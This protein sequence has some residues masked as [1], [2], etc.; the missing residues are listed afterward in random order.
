MPNLRNESEKVSLGCH[1]HSGQEEVLSLS[2][3][4]CENLWAKLFVNGADNC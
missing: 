2:Y 3:E 1:Y 4:V